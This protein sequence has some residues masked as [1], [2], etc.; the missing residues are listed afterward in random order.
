[1]NKSKAIEIAAGW[2]LQNSRSLDPALVFKVLVALGFILKR[3]V[4]QDTTYIFSH[5][6]LTSRKDFSFGYMYIS[7]NHGKNKN[8][9]S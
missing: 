3:K 9:P 2:L 1:M 4:K 5:S 8:L 6:C 7:V